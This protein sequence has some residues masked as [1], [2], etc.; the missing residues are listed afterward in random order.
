MDVSVVND[1]SRNFFIRL[2]PSYSRGTHMESSL[3][4]KR[5]VIHY[6]KEKTLTVTANG[7]SLR[8]CTDGEITTQKRVEF[9]I[10]KD[11]FR[12]IVPSGKQE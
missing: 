11:A 4:D 7:D 6:T 9:S 10:V 12:F 8:L 5:D 2:F 3:I 1:I